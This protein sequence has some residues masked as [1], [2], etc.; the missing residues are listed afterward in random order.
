MHL[1]RDN[2]MH[3]WAHSEWWY[4]VGHISD[5]R[6]QR[7]GFE[8][9]LFKFTNLQLPGSKSLFS[10]DK[11]DVALTDVTRHTF[12]H[13]VTY[14]EPGLAPVSLSTRRFSE[15][16]GPDRMWSTSNTLHLN[17]ATGGTLLRLN[18]RPTR[19]DI[20]E[21]G[22][23][24][25]PMG[26]HG[27][28]YYYSYPS[29]AVHGGIFYRGQWRSVSGI[30]WLDHQWG[31]WRWSDILGWTWGAFQ[32]DNGVDLS[33]SN[34]RAR[35]QSLRGVTVSFP[36]ARQRTITD[37]RISAT[38]HWRSPANGVTYTSGWVVTIPRLRARLTVRPLLKDQLVYDPTLPAASYWEGDCS[39]AG[40]FA[41]HGIRGQAYM[42]LAGGS[43]RFQIP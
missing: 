26:A 34:F 20:L 38:G 18:L 16:L 35:G 5:G 43:Q 33:V 30:A 6:G 15:R 28:S 3:S 10:V 32:L 8:T 37:M 11:A 41:G 39:V 14:I 23:G 13:S 29:L 12:L 36:R 19:R 9:T 25:V 31:N 24:V 17:A 2:A 21:G 7:Y 42:E 1:P 22:D 27:F 4:V 40:T